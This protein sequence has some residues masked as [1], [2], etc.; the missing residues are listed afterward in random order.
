M[1]R[2]VHKGGSRLSPCRVSWDNQ[3]HVY[4]QISE[5]N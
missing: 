5:Y 3:K 4:S 1:G 2:K